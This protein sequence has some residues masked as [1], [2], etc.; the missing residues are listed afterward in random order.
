[1]RRFGLAMVLA[2]ALGT[3]AARAADLTVWGLQIGR[4]HV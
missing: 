3:G 1:M 4:A 2:A